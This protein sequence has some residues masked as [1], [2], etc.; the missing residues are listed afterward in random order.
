MSVI[1]NLLAIKNQGMEY[2]LKEQEQKY[3]NAGGTFCVHDGKRY[4]TSLT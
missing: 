3:V 4:P 2:F 1:E